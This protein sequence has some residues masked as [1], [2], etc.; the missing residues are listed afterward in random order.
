M[1]PP[2]VANAVA[3]PPG[4]ERIM[5]LHAVGTVNYECRP[6]TG[7]AG[8][9]A[10]TL[11]AYDASLRHWTGLRVGRLYQGP[12]WA[13]RDGS[14]LTGQLAGSVSG[15]AGH[16]PLQLWRTRASGKKGTLS[17]VVFVRRVD[18]TGEPPPQARC[19]A[20]RAGA[21]HPASME[22]DYEF[23]ARQ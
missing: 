16:L 9:H 19:T 18:A 1:R 5:T 22:A 10:W 14:R 15:G 8:A 11:A 12:T 20:A 7:M 3:I 6:V 13:Y 2:E 23:Y 21:L 17:S 4:H